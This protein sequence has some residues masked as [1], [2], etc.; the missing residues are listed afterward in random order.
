MWV[1]S[2]I[3]I[4]C[5]AFIICSANCTVGSVSLEIFLKKHMINSKMVQNCVLGPQMS[6]DYHVKMSSSVRCEGEPMWS[7]GLWIVHGQN[8]MLEHKLYRVER[9][10][11]YYTLKSFLWLLNIFL[12]KFWILLII[13]HN[14]R[15]LL[16]KKNVSCF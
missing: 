2:Q 5:R 4:Q 10:F 8:D 6:N 12:N 3:L 9:M 13:F 11:R 7:K 1:C 14:L 16:A 15:V